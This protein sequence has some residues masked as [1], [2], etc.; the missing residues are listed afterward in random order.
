M[1]STWISALGEPVGRSETQLWVGLTVVSHLP[2]H[3]GGTGDSGRGGER[4]NGVGGLGAFVSQHFVNT[5]RA[6]YLWVVEVEVVVVVVV[7]SCIPCQVPAPQGGQ[8]RLVYSLPA[9]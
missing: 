1:S 3:W 4:R 7:L 5:M 8:F 2:S 6:F 9:R